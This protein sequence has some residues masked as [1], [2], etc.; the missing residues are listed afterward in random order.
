VHP[1][2]VKATN[3]AAKL[4]AELGHLVEEDEPTIDGIELAKSYFMMYFGEIAADL[5]ELKIFLK[6]RLKSNDIEILTRML[7]L[8]G[9]TYT[10][11]EFVSSMRSWN[12]A[13]RAV[14]TFFQKYDVYLTPTIACPPVKIGELQ[15][16]AF[17]VFLMKL[18]T[19]LKLGAI[20]KATGAVEKIAVETLAKT[21][22]TQLAN[23]TGLPAMSV[24]LHWTANGLPCGVQCIG[25]FGDEATLFRLAAQLEKAR[26]WFNKRPN[27]RK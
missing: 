23:I 12:T 25:R 1:E 9:N 22:F 2:C 27:I 15:P 10:A 17:L 14:G 3:D 19:T 7:A 11:G 16:P 8:M 6:R 4:L 5:D 18:V 26:P 24:P 13:S 21:P 20:A